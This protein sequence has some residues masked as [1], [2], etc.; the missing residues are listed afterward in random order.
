MSTCL[1]TSACQDHSGHVE[2]VCEELRD[3]WT[4]RDGSMFLDIAM[5]RSCPLV[6]AVLAVPST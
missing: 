6:G 3:V 5:G 2:G 4:E 1:S